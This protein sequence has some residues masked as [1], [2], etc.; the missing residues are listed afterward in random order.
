[1]SKLAETMKETLNYTLTEKLAL[2]HKSTMSEVLDLFSSIGGRR[3]QDITKHFSRAFAENETLAVLTAFYS[4]DPRSGQGERELFRQIL[5]WLADNKPETF[6]KIFKLVP[7]F[8]RFDDLFALVAHETV[9]QDVTAFLKKQFFDDL[10]SLSNNSISLISKWLPSNNTSSRDSRRLAAFFAKEFGLTPKQYR[11]ALSKLRAKLKVVE[12]DMSANN[13]GGINYSHVPSYASKLYRKAFNR[14]DELRYKEFLANVKGGKAKIN[15]SVLYPYDLVKEYLSWAN[16][17]VDQ[18]IEA[19]W[20]ALPNYAETSE[21]ALVIADLSGSMFNGNNPSPAQIAISL[22]IY[23][24]ERN[25]GIFKEYWMNFSETPNLIKLTGATLYER[26][27]NLDRDNWGCTTNLQSAF[28]MILNTAVKADISQAEM[29]TKLFI[30]SDFEWDQACPR[31]D[32]TN[33]QVIKQKYENS[34][35]K[36]PQIIFW[37]VAARAKQSPV[38]MNE[39]GVF[40]VSGASPSIFKNAIRAE[41]K[42]PY[43]LMLEVL[44]GDRYKAVRE[45]LA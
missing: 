44:N 21:N 38:T 14:H 1:M 13:W 24:A 5:S 8:G 15:A 33:F 20:K 2:T 34:G 18:T 30:V 39:S 41:A 25:T 28:N 37:N 3:G 16:N 29:P 42:T 6:N 22:A 19:Q 11:Q 35:Y 32:K 43:E 36:L 26:V 12:R 7:E 10:D 40:L 27:K 23:V 4:R 17:G 31:N 45:V 9:G